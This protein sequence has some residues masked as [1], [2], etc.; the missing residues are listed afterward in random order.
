MATKIAIFFTDLNLK[1]KNSV[2]KMRCVDSLLNQF[3]LT[4]DGHIYMSLVSAC[5]FKVITAL[6]FYRNNRT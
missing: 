2:A 5:A 1:K 3:S 6:V 4:V